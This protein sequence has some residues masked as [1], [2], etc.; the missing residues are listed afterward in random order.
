MANNT[1]K[2]YGGRQKGTPNKLTAEI[3]QKLSQIIEAE[4]ERIPEYLNSI[5]RPELK[6]KLLID[7]LPFVIPKQKEVNAEHQAEINLP[8][9]MEDKITITPIHYVNTEY[10]DNN[11]EDE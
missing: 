11:L 1:G 9:W 3:K 2:K 4:S 10:N 5:E 7:L 8:D 6:L